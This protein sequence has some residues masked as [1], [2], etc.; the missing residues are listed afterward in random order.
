[1]ICSDLRLYSLYTFIL[2]IMAPEILSLINREYHNQVSSIILLYLVS[3][4][5]ILF[6]RMGEATMSTII[7]FY[8]IQSYL[9]GLFLSYQLPS[10]LFTPMLLT[11]SIAIC[12]KLIYGN[13][14]N[15]DSDY[16]LSAQI[17]LI[18]LFNMSNYPH[19][20][21]IGLYFV[22]KFIPSML[23]NIKDKQQL[24]D[25]YH[26]SIVTLTVLDYII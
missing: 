11:V 4:L 15:F 21:K 13:S 17:L 16:I 2:P 19:I 18:L 26:F 12:S 7:V 24:L 3:N 20:L 25:L 10:L 5:S 14:K 23:D 1:M 6:A 9:I 22:S 8:N